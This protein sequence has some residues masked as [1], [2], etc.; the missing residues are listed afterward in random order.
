MNTLSP[1]KRLFRLLSVDRADI[2]NIYICAGLNG[3]ISL[4]I[5]L[6][7]QA[8]IGL[9]MAGSVSASW[10]L[11]VG[12][13][14]IGVLGTGVLLIMQVTLTEIL[15][16]RLFVR[17]AIEFTYR[18]PKV[19]PE[20]LGG[21]YAP[22]LVNRFFDTTMVQ[23]GLPKVLIDLPSAILQ[24]VFGLL[25]LSFYHPYFIIFGL[26]LM[27]LL[28]AIFRFTWYSGLH[29]SL[30]ESKYKYK[31]AYWLEELARSLYTFKQAGDSPLPMQRADALLKGYLGARR[32]H[33]RVLMLQLVSTVAFKTL[34]TAALLTLG[35]LLVM[36][37]ALSIGQF[38]ASEIVII[39]V[40]NASEKLIGAMESVYDT[41]TAIEKV[42]T[43]ADLP[44]ERTGGR[45][46]VPNSSKG[47]EVVLQNVTHSFAE[48]P[49]EVL[50]GLDLAIDPGTRVAVCGSTGSGKSVLMRMIG[51]VLEPTQGS[52][53]YDGQP[54]GSLA[55]ASLR[56]HVAICTAED[57]VFNGTVEEN[58][59]LGRPGI[60]AEAVIATLGQVGLG[61]WL[62]SLPLGL[63]TVLDPEGRRLP[64]SV[65]QR[66]LVAR[67]IVQRP[68]LIVME[69][70]LTAVP[71]AQRRQV[72]EVLLDRTAPWTLVI[73]TTD[74]E[75]ISHCDRSIWLNEGRIATTGQKDRSGL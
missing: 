35:G 41:L 63:D 5:P 3:L 10:L 23:K 8:V 30:N 68:L 52:L 19:R 65:S 44:L 14:V 9:I 57:L 70:V 36:D 17:S 6:G 53:S 45:E 32:S 61:E 49:A 39:L 7:V 43:V 51:G 15:Q 16:Q 22:E 66:L 24:I 28:A 55:L 11:L 69:D 59:G 58:V 42:G 46:L 74:T 67:A 75:V 38:V 48:G 62:R 29:S 20:A 12:L 27:L 33:F 4:T 47:L 71:T 64:R 25:L 31:V 34:I 50:S 73:S 60:G 1:A 37:G 2:I 18:I 56:R 13:V 21:S 54:I 40:L 72:Y 26:M